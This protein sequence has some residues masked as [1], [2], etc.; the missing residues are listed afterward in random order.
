MNPHESC[1]IFVADLPVNED[2]NQPYCLIDEY[3]LRQLFQG[4]SMSPYAV[5]I[6]TKIGCNGKPYAYAL[7]QFDTHEQAMEA[8][9]YFNYTKLN[10]I[11]IRLY[12]A[13]YE[14]NSIIKNGQG[15]ILIKNLDPEIE[16]S[17]L[18][19]AFANFG[20]VITCEIPSDLVIRGDERKYVS[21]GYGYV[22]FR[23]PEDAKQAIVDLKGASINGR[24]IEI[25]HFD[26]QQDLNPEQSFTYCY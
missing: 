25:Q 5:V 7:I 24:P 20:E 19:D 6:Q 10:N 15:K 18:H 13:D 8:I 16:V 12:M 11:P 2:S 23:N 4:V 3:F 26:I 17:Q 1:T 14:T 21:R 9:E 22:Q